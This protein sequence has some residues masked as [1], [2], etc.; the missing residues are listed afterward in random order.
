LSTRRVVFNNVTTNESFTFDGLRRIEQWTQDTAVPNNLIT[1][2]YGPSGDIQYRLVTGETVGYAPST[3]G[4]TTTPFV[5]RLAL[6]NSRLGTTDNYDS[7]ALGRTTTSP[8]GSFTYTSYDLPK[9]FAATTGINTDYVYDAFGN[10]LKKAQSNGAAEI[11][12]GGLFRS[13]TSTAG[14]IT[15]E[16]SLLVEGNVIGAIQ[17]T[18]AAGAYA[19]VQFFH[20]DLV[21]T[22]RATATRTGGLSRNAVRD[23]FGNRYGNGS[24]FLPNDTAGVNG[25]GFHGY[26]SQRHDVP[27]GLIDMNGRYYSPRIGRFMSDDPIVGD[28]TDGRTYS[29]K[30]WA[31]VT[32]AIARTVAAVL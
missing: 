28:P 31:R 15:Y 19:L 8:M 25:E 26:Q 13:I 23:P 20:R 22:T 7:D 32:R 16:H 6:S 30:A 14:L 9:R 4:T 29:P 1:Y 10:A 18:S 21:G 24:P 27:A 2:I 5:S 12:L 3:S 17:H 11:D